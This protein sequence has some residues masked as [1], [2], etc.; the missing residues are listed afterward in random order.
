MNNFA[1]VFTDIFFNEIFYDFKVLK[2]IDLLNNEIVKKKIENDISRTIIE[3]KRIM[4]KQKTKNAISYVQII[5]KICYDIR[6]IF[7]DLKINQKVYIKLHKI[8]SQFDLKNR[9]FNKQRL[10]SVIIMKKMSRLIYKL[11]ISNI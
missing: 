9:K 6:H 11:D 5:I 1:N 8:Y 2:A 4:F 7:I 10:E 3:K